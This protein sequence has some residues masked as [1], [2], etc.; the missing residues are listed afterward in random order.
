LKGQAVPA[1]SSESPDSPET[2]ISVPD[3]L[4]IVHHKSLV[5]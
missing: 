3:S 4:V 2:T 1:H 5:C